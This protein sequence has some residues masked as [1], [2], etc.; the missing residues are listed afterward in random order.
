MGELVF[1]FGPMGSGKSLELLRNAHHRESIGLSVVTVKPQTDSKG[2]N[3]ITARGA[4]PGREVDILMPEDM[5]IQAAIND[6][7]EQ[8]ELDPQRSIVLVDEAQFSAIEQ[9]DALRRVAEFDGVSE[10]A[11]YGLR[12]DFRIELFPAAKRFLEL[13]TRIEQ[14]KIPCECGKNDAHY[15]TRRIDGV[16]V[17]EGE[18]V[19]IDGEYV[20]E[21]Q[22]LSVR[23]MGEVT[24][25]ALCFRCY[26]NEKAAAKQTP[27]ALH[28]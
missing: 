19:A 3:Q 28:F 21:D 26:S 16:Y 6:N 22:V 10:V 25:N 13:A 4:V 15:N 11:A 12:T 14:L 7:I 18:Q 23:D 24:Y 17:F 9:V 8:R 5:D 1:T 27:A 2:G 20:G